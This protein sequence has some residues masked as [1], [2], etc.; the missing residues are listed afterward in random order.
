MNLGIASLIA[1][2]E[3]LVC[4]DFGIGKLLKKKKKKTNLLGDI[5]FESCQ[6]NFMQNSIN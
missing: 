2:T 1:Y 4:V 3:S 6:N 5:I